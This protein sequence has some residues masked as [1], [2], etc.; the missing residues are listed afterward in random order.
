MLRREEGP[1][2]YNRS[3]VEEIKNSENLNF[4][5]DDKSNNEAQSLKTIPLRKPL[6]K[7]SHNL[8]RIEKKNVAAD[9]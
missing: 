2:A 7:K 4:I 3:R 5:K 9:R 1:K 8:L 6:L